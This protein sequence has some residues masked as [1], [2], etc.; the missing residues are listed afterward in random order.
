MKSTGFVE[1]IA[2]ILAIVIVIGL[3]VWG[4]SA[5]KSNGYTFQDVLNWLGEFGLWIFLG[6]LALAI[7]ILL[8]ILVF[9]WLLIRLPLPLAVFGFLALANG[10]TVLGIILLSAAV[11]IG[12][13][14]F[15]W[16]N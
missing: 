12:F 8:L 5:L 1:V 4:I 11:V 3:I 9:S 13:I 7:A 15:F 6:L 2:K 16:G 14:A 10:Y